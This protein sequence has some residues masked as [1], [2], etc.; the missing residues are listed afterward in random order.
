[1][2]LIKWKPLNNQIDTFDNVLDQF[3]N[4]FA[5]D[6]RFSLTTNQPYSYMNEN[7][8]EYYLNMDLPGLEK[9]D[10]NARVEN[11]HVIVSGERKNDSINNNFYG[12]FEQIF[13][14]PENVKVDKIKASLKNGV[15]NIIFP[16]DKNAIGK[17]IDIK[18]S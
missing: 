10:I 9:E 18:I 1:M 8:K 5:F 15:L 7:K 14:I 11:N 4:D 3:F 12:K 17:E 16:K 13:K 2:S 6:P